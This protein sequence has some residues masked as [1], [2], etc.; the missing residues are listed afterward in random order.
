MCAECGKVH[1]KE[2]LAD[3]NKAEQWKLAALAAGGIIALLLIW[4]WVFK[5]GVP[6]VKHIQGIE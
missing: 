4:V 2:E 3:S 1:V 6:L 5:W